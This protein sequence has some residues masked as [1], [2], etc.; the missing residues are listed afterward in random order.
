MFMSDAATTPSPTAQPNPDAGG[1]GMGSRVG[2]LLD[3]VRKLIDYGKGLAATLQQRSTT[4]DPDL[5]LLPFGTRDLG[6]ILAR[7]TRGLHR[8]NALEARVV[9]RAAYLDAGPKAPSTSAQRKPRAQPA[10]RH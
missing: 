3:L 6:L 9:S 1:P 5:A 4:G 7:I 10:P 2:R 8:A